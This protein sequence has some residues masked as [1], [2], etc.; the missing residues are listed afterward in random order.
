MTIRI[1]DFASRLVT[2]LLDDVPRAGGQRHAEMWDGM[3]AGERVANGAY[4]YRLELTGGKVVFGKVV[5][6]D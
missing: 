6:L 3:A 1:Y 4:L 5:V 2:T